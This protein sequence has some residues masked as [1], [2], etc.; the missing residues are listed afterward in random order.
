[1]KYVLAAIAGI[2]MADG[3]ALLVAPT[4]V[5]ARLRE[6][7]ALAPKILRWEAVAAVLGLV[8]V[9]GTQGLRYQSLWV[10]TGTAMIFKGL[11][12]TLGPDPWRHR[13][14]EWC[15]HREEVDYRFWGL[16]LCTLAVLL[17]DALVAWFRAG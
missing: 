6:V 13:L 4:H 8:L 11:F 7:L 3:L 12:L 2:W 16:A 14:L 17:L 10:I 1:M 9:L 5:I 15:L